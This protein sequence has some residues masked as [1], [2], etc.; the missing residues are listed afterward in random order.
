MCSEGFDEMKFNLHWGDR[1]IIFKWFKEPQLDDAVVGVMSNVTANSNG[2]F[3]F[4]NH[5]L[6]LDYDD[7][8]SLTNLITEIKRL[9]NKFNLPTA[10]IFE[11]S[12]RHYNVFFFGV[13]RDYFECLKVIHDTPCDMEYKMARMQREE[14][15]LRITPKKGKKPPELVHIIESPIGDYDEHVKDNVILTKEMD[16][17][18]EFVLR[19][20]GDKTG[21][22]MFLDVA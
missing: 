1:N 10:H 16:K 7:N 21:E 17:I 3:W 4:E 19:S 8:L 11:S 12:Y 18:K 13:C 14:M 2:A 22:V 15:T 20:C 5:F 9:Q 6:M